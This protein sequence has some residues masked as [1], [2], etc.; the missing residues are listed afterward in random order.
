M[1]LSKQGY[2]E[3]LSHEGICLSPYLD[4]VGV[5]TIGG[6]V[7][8]FDGK[9]INASTPPLTLDQALNQYKDKLQPYI[10][11]VDSVTKLA[12]SKGLEQNQFDALVSFHY[13]T[14]AIGKATLTKVVNTDPQA[15]AR[16]KTEFLKW[17]IPPEIIGRRTKE[18][19]LYT[20]GKYSNNGK[21][22]V[23]PVN[24]KHKPVYSKGQSIDVTKYF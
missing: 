14:G 24:S 17:K 7:T 18:M 4:S 16:I 6:G 1:Q 5:W 13:N 11:K 20:T 23:F 15:L 3:I 10:D 21:A 2:I 19:L 12:Q 8:S 22:L 9:R